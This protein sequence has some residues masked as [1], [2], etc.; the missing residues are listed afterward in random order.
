MLNAYLDRQAT[1]ISGEEVRY[2]EIHFRGLK[3]NSQ[4]KPIM[5]FTKKKIEILSIWLREPF[6]E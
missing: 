1:Y 2:K 3:G 5:K 4:P 6:A